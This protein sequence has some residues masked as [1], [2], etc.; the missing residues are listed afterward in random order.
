MYTAKAG[1]SFV[2]LKYI[3]APAEDIHL[4]VSFAIFMTFLH[5]VVCSLKKSLRVLFFNFLVQYL[6]VVKAGCSQCMTL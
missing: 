5:P 2:V 3:R 6:Q 4:C 1:G